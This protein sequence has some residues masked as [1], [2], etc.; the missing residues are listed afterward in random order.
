[1]Y[2]RE[3]IHKLKTITVILYEPKYYLIY[4]IMDEIIHL[5]STKSINIL[6]TSLKIK[7]IS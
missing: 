3:K 7:I 2:E 1:M 5:I 4:Y 6:Y